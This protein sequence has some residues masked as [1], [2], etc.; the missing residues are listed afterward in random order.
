MSVLT[1]EAGFRSN[2]GAGEAAFRLLAEA[3]IGLQLTQPRAAPGIEILLAGLNA[4]A[5]EAHPISAAAWY[6]IQGGQL[7]RWSIE[8]QTY[9]GL[10]APGALPQTAVRRRF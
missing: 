2:A 6:R 1:S 10:P 5:Q 9:E 8:R 3:V 7:Q 4:A